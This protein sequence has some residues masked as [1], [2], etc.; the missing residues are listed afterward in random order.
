MTALTALTFLD[1]WHAS[2]RAGMRR[3]RMLWWLNTYHL[4]RQMVDANQFLT[5]GILVIHPMR[6]GLNGHL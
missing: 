4:D 3:R 1:V 6:T 5:R 2:R